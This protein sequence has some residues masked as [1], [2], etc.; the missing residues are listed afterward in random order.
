[1]A[2]SWLG[3][4]VKEGFAELRDGLRRR[5]GRA[6][7]WQGW[8]KWLGTVNKVGRHGLHGRYIDTGT[9]Q[10]VGDA[11]L[12]AMSH[13]GTSQPTCCKF[14]CAGRAAWA[15]NG[16][17]QARLTT[18]APLFLRRVF[19]L[20]TLR[21][22]HWLQ[23]AIASRAARSNSRRLQVT[24][25]P[26]LSCYPSKGTEGYSAP[27]L[28]TA[29]PPHTCIPPDIGPRTSSPHHSRAF[30]ARTIPL[31]QHPPAATLSHPVHPPPC[32]RSRLA[33]ILSV[34]VSYCTLGTAP[35]YTT[36]TLCAH[37]AE[38]AQ[39]TRYPP[40]PHPSTSISTTTALCPVTFAYHFAAGLA[41][42]SSVS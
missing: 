20:A 15:L 7:G 23:A 16:P 21:G 32:A 5:R 4:G 29:P 24:R 26:C 2:I 37:A 1:M 19:L 3:E 34:S 39:L 35:S 18:L 12:A 22:S 8:Q 27:H 13:Q 14:T 41:V 28:G 25:G 17:K 33:A 42:R 6:V 30:R 38:P 10:Y 36:T 40:P 9:V 31:P 11:G